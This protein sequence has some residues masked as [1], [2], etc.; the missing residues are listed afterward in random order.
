LAGF[1]V[2]GL[3]LAHF[4][5]RRRPGEVMALL[6]ILYSLTRWPVEALRADERAVFAGMTASQN[7]SV[8]L[9]SFGLAIWFGLRGSSASAYVSDHPQS[10]GAAA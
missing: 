10:P 7:I 2:L 9:L 1:V 5:R 3:L 6:M 4:P 8:A